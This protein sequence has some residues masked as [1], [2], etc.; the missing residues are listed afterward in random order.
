MWGKK[1][2]GESWFVGARG[3]CQL[4]EYLL[5][6]LLRRDDLRTNWYLLPALADHM[7]SSVGKG[8]P[9]DGLATLI[10][11]PRRELE[12]EEATRLTRL[13]ASVLTR[14]VKLQ[15]HKNGWGTRFQKLQKAEYE[16]KPEPCWKVILKFCSLEMIF[17]SPLGNYR[18]LPR[19]R[20][21]LL[22]PQCFWVIPLTF[23]TIIISFLM[24]EIISIWHL[25]QIHR[26]SRKLASFFFPQET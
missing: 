4:I 7:Q 18:F 11:V 19:Q 24:F 2:K 12:E 5:V 25:E 23:P 15:G 10:S 16:L 9:W 20:E 21:F 17:P 26:I 1:G 3:G 8:C 22:F 13:T 6:A 14:H